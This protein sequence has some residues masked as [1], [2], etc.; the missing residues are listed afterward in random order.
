MCPEIV[1]TR[2]SRPLLLQLITRPPSVV[3]GH[4][5][6][7][8]GKVVTNTSGRPDSWEAKATKSSR[9]ENAAVSMTQGP[10]KRV[11][12]RDANDHHDRWVPF[13]SPTKT[14]RDLP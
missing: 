7:R 9:G 6:R 3:I 12:V 11:S 8:S 13:S 14:S 2:S 1:A 10:A 4:V 5:W